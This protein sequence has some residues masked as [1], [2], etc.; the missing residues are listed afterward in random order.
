MVEL[1]A[2][3]VAA[4][5]EDPPEVRLD[6]CPV[7]EYAESAERQPVEHDVTHQCAVFVLLESV[8]VLPGAIWP[9]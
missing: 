2:D 7:R 3:R 4:V 5:V 6:D 8:R 1:P 9:G